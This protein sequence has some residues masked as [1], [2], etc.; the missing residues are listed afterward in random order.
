MSDGEPD[1]PSE[2]AEVDREVHDLLAAAG[3]SLRRTAASRSGSGGGSDVIAAALRARVKRLRLRSVV[4]A[5]AAVVLLA[6]L[7]ADLLPAGS[8]SGPVE[9]ASGRDPVADLL[10]S[11]PERPVDPSDVE[12][13]PTV[14]RFEDCDSLRDRLRRVGAEHVGSRGFG[15]G[16]SYV[17]SSYTAYYDDFAAGAAV[18]DSSGSAGSA[19]AAP[20]TSG[21]P[22]LGTN[23]IVDGVDEPDQVKAVDDL[24]VQIAGFGLRVID[25]SVPAV[26]GA[27]G[28]TVFEE[29]RS[30]HSTSL[31]L[32][33]RTATVFGSETVTAPAVEGDP[34]ATRPST[35]FLTVTTVDLSDPTAPVVV[36]R[37]RI[38]GG[39]VA[40][41]RVGRQVRMVTSSSMRDLPFV[42]PAVPDAV[43]PALEDN[44]EAVARSGVHDWIPE[45][46]HGPGTDARPLVSCGDLVVPDTF[47]G[48]QMTSMVSFDMGGFEPRTLGLLAPSDHITATAEDVVIG[49][50]VWVDPAV[51]QAEE[52]GLQDWSTA[53]HRFRFT[54]G[55]PRYVGSGEV[56]GSLRSDFSMAVLADGSVGAVTAVGDPWSDRAHAAVRLEILAESGD[57][58]LVSMAGLELGTGSTVAGLRFIGDKLLVSSGPFE[59]VVSVVD[60]SR[61]GEPAAAG[62]IALGGTGEYFHPLEGSRVMVVGSTARREGELLMP[63]VHATVLDLS[64]APVAVASWGTEGY[65]Q[66]IGSEHHA[67]TWWSERS[68]AAFGLQRSFP[69]PNRAAFLGVGADG[70]DAV[71]V[72]PREAPLGPPCAPDQ[73][74][75]SACD[76]TGPASVHRVLVVEGVPWLLTGESL[77]GLDPVSF[78]S[79]ALVALR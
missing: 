27:V 5:A 77:E 44:R 2:D 64:A 55:E 29:G 43:A 78:E 59:N 63:G 65:H 68:L 8:P 37:A 76:G 50:G 18:V 16:S 61:P 9:L 20:S 19:G 75:R 31:L 26:V 14:S 36:D 21:G 35:Q 41:R 34:S 28:L 70:I 67:F 58:E 15:G 17:S 52:L 7:V 79:F 32:E 60:L 57:D 48:V 40:A 23:V 13:V 73:L 45:W 39:L 11:L 1:G 69:G 33:G 53:L 51:V 47:A 42:H 6:V 24:V 38:E 12:L 46:D 72:E 4:T 10:D 74:D 3:E 62:E 49:A 25:T 66:G 71:P 22:T 56:P 30:A 54:D